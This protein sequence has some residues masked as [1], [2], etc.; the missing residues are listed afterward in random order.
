MSD[1]T[2]LY[3]RQRRFLARFV[4]LEN[5]LNSERVALL[6]EYALRLHVELG[7]VYSAAHLKYDDATL[8]DEENAHLLEEIVDCFKY[9]L[10]LL[11]VQGFSPEDFVS[12]FDKKSTIVESRKVGI[13][14]DKS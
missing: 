4:D 6:K 3:E 13:T 10:N 5:L 8:T 12:M 7:E 14:D 11:I 1:I 9:L 2:V